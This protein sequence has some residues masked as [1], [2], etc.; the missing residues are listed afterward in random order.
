[1][2]NEAHVSILDFLYLCK[3]LNELILDQC[4]VYFPHPDGLN[5]NFEPHRILKKLH[6][7]NKNYPFLSSEYM[8]L[9]IAR[10][11]PNL[12]ELV[13]RP[14]P[15]HKGFTLTTIKILSELAKLERLEVPVSTEDTVNNMPSFVYVLR[16][17]PSLRFLTLSWGASPPE[18]H[19]GRTCRMV[20]W[21]EHVLQADNANIYVQICHELH[22]HVYSNPPLLNG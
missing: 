2:I 17:F 5:I 3:N 16:E 10:L 12:E 18:I 15:N 4:S 9:S 8:T 22:N 7:V 6:V 14:E 20:D 1:M 19:Q 21:L 11:I 13:L